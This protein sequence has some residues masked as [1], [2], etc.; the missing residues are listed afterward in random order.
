MVEQLDKYSI[1]ISKIEGLGSVSM[2]FYR[3]NEF[4]PAGLDT[5]CHRIHILRCSDKESYMMNVLT[6]TWLAAFRHL[7]NRQVIGT[8]GQVR[9]VWI[10]FPLH[11][12]P[13]NGTVKI[14]GFTHVPDIES[15]VPKT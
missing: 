13:Q 6:R 14:D 8:R 5:G 10:R 12:H 15:D 3:L 2:D 1:G 7:V 11:P 4:N 9:I